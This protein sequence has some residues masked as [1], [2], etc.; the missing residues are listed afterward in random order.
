MKHESIILLCEVLIPVGACLL[1]MFL[2]TFWTLRQDRKRRDSLDRKHLLKLEE[3]L[4]ECLS[5]AEI[6]TG[7]A[8]RPDEIIRQKGYEIKEKLF[9]RGG[10]AST[11]QL[12]DQYV[13][14]WKLLPKKR[15]NFALAHELMHIIYEPGELNVSQ[16]KRATHAFFRK[17]DASEQDRDYMAASLILP[18]DV[19]WKDLTDADYFNLSLADKKDFIYRAAQKYNVELSTVFRRIDELKV[20]MQ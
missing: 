1:I 5:L 2:R 20:M 13:Y 18:R 17:R 7:A 19:F 14:V 10:E 8:V 3:T 9:V 4:N 12:P 11:S 16:Q 15:K 6:H